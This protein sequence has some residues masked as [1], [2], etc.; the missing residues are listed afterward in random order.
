MNHIDY[1][2]YRII[3]LESEKNSIMDILSHHM[4]EHHPEFQPLCRQ[5]FILNDKIKTL[6]Q[7]QQKL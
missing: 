2:K 3:E 4:Q 7:E 1:L 5:V 6:Q